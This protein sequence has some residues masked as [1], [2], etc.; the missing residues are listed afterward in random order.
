MN[1][2]D[3]VWI[4]QKWDFLNTQI[5]I[6]YLPCSVLEK[7]EVDTKETETQTSFSNVQL[8]TDEAQIYMVGVRITRLCAASWSERIPKKSRWPQLFCHLF[9]ETWEECVSPMSKDTRHKYN[10][11]KICCHHIP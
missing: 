8:N 9:G 11:K 6:R 7:I 5:K 4:V 10:I 2:Y 1:Q 3:N